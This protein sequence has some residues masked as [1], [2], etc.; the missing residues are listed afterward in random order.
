[1]ATL[2]I[3]DGMDMKKAAL[4]LLAAATLFF[5][6]GCG[7]RMWEDT[8]ETTADT[9]NYV[10][11]TEPTAR[12][13]H[14][15]AEVPIIELNHRAADVL[16]SN[17]AKG[18][19]TLQSAVF[20]RQFSNQSDPSD[21]SIFGYVMTQQVTDRLVQRG[22]LITEGEPNATDYTYSNNLTAADYVDSGGLQTGKE[23]VLPPRSARLTGTYVIG[24]NY[25]YMHAKVTR[26]VDS[27]VVSAHDWVL[28]ITDNI[29][30]ML[31]QLKVEE[32][33]TPTVDTSFD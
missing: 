12:S 22:V 13:Y 27:A 14:D 17:V 7:N 16:Y 1:M 31:P 15:V 18:E 23:K 10:F 3:R 28:P 6:T 9:F 20:V 29:R 21:A 11:D 2:A 19:L 24:D 5:T 33:L 4:M 25:I 8:K 30:Q 32:G 26:L